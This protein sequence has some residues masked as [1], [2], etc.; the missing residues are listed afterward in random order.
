MKVV[1]QPVVE[2]ITLEEARLQCSIDAV[3]SP[4]ASVWDPMLARFITSAREWA[5]SYLGRAIAAQTVEIPYTAFPTGSSSSGYNAA[6]DFT[7][8]YDPVLAVESILYIDND[9]G[10]LL[11][12]DDS[13]Y[14]LNNDDVLSRIILGDGQTWPMAKNQPGSVRVRYVVGY[15]APGDS[16]NT[17]PL[18][19]S[20]K[21]ALLLLVGHLYK[22]RENTSVIQMVEIP[23]GVCFW[24]NPY[25]LTNGF[26]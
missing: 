7:F 10:A 5:E 25:K 15:T 2:P 17:A 22:N 9:T 8:L 14:S 24:L 16:P 4:P 23:N 11:V 21:T 20:I 18:P 6:L 1:S 3:G 19:N 26:A 13:T 12:V